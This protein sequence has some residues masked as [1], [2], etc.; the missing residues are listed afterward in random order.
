[1]NPLSVIDINWLQSQ[2]PDLSN[3]V[4]LNSGGQKQVFAAEHA[5]DGPVVL[6]IIHPHQD[7][8]TTKREILAVTKRSGQRVPQ[9]LKV[10]ALATQLG[11]CVWFRE[12]RITGHSIRS[13]IACGPLGESKLLKLGLQTLEVLVA[14]ERLRIVHRD[15]KPE[16]LMCDGR[17][18][19]WVI[20]FG[21]A[22]HL[23]LNSLTATA[24]VFGKYT[25][26]YAPPEQFK[27]QKFEIDARCDLFSLGVTLY[28][29]ATGSNPYI[30]GARDALE[31]FRRI[32][33]PPLPRLQLSFP[34][35]NDFADIVA[36]MTQPR[37]D[38]RPLTAAETYLW[39]KQICQAENI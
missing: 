10:A 13:L 8:E 14:A 21:L 11:Q 36:A 2:F 22:R 31:V 16:N 18:D 38:H 33:G 25:V 34:S 9:I 5:S 19:A 23:D 29:C 20:D 39:M 28:E 7:L 15:I 32:Q 24:A 37:R 4:P 27:N 12:R 6:K 30:N 26:G 35:S 1:M 17:D 3:L